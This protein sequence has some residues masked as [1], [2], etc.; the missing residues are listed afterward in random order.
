MNAHCERWVRSVK[1]EVLSKL[2]LFG[3]GALRHCLEHYL[4]HYHSER[5]HQGQGNV[6]LFPT[7]A[8]RIGESSGGIRNR[9]CPGGLLRFCYREA[10]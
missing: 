8:D 3:E 9:E 6:I 2:I 1:T 5:D 10:A 7:P 4:S